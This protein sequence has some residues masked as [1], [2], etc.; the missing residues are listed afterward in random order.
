MSRVMPALIHPRREI[1]QSEYARTPQQIGHGEIGTM[2]Q[3]RSEPPQLA[4]QSP[5]PPPAL[6]GIARSAAALQ[7]GRRGGWHAEGLV[8]DQE[9]FV[10]RIATRQRETEFGSVARQPTAGEGERSGLNRH[11][12]TGWGYDRPARLL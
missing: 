4:R 7:I 2:H 6:H 1:V 12:H 11:A 10:F 9:E 8:G 5:E 3:V